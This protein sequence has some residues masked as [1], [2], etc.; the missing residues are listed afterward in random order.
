MADHFSVR[1]R[2]FQGCNQVLASSH[3]HTV[4]I[5]MKMAPIL[6][7]RARANKCSASGGLRVLFD[8]LDQLF[9]LQLIEDRQAVA[10]QLSGG[11]TRSTGE[12][13]AE[14][15]VVD[16]LVATGRAARFHQG[17]AAVMSVCQFKGFFGAAEKLGSDI[18]AAAGG[19]Q[20]GEACLGFGGW[21]RGG[22]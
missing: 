9:Q 8:K 1:R 21:A 6:G 19:D 11:Y 20:N 22:Q 3:R 14:T 17:A 12:G 18:F 15:A 2:L 4:R 7:G 16:F 5:R 13:A 10:N